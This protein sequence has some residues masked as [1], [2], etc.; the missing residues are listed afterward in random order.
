MSQSSGDIDALFAELRTEWDASEALVKAAEQVS[1]DA[2]I[3]SIKEFRYAGRRI[4]DALHEL[5]ASGDGAKAKA[6]VQDAIFNCHCARHDAIDVATG[7]MASTM[8]VA[9]EKIGYQH[10]LAAFPKFAE[11][12]KKLSEA[13]AK[14]RVSRQNRTDRDAIY[15]SIHVTD[16][17]A[18]IELYEEYQ[19]AEDVMKSL[20]KG[21]RR[22]ILFH[23]VTTVIL[24][25]AAVGSM[26]VAVF[27]KPDCPTPPAQTGALAS[28]AG[29]A[30][31]NATH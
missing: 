10:I 25:I 17:P 29:H 28:P 16:F 18:L 12:R 21:Q 8:S 14:I 9:V 31:G 23:R 2:I 19:S 24:V 22:E 11:L 4:V 13:R 5:K 3:P 20:A 27:R 1:G 30:S 6:F 26:L 15:Q 7:I